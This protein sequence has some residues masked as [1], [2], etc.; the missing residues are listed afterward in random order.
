MVCLRKLHCQIFRLR[1]RATMV[2]PLPPLP[3]RIS[4]GKIISAIAMLAAHPIPL[5]DC[6]FPPSSANVIISPTKQ[7]AIEMAAIANAMKLAGR[8]PRP[9]PK[10]G[11]HSSDADE[12]GQSLFGKDLKWGQLSDPNHSLNRGSL[13]ITRTTFASDRHFP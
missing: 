10:K 5:T 1:T 4:Q 8:I 3:N 12:T 7:S 11:Q 2:N 9:M 13:R 6:S